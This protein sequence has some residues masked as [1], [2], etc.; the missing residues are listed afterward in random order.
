VER[1]GL[2][3]GDVIRAEDD[4]VVVELELLPASRNV[5]LS[6]ESLARARPDRDGFRAPQFEG[7]SIRIRTEGSRGSGGVRFMG[8]SGDE[9]APE[10]GAILLSRLAANEAPRS[11]AVGTEPVCWLYHVQI[12]EGPAEEQPIDPTLEER[13]RELGYVR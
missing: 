6:P 7:S 5:G 11:L 9:L 8:A 2:E 13:L 4:Q 10:D 3:V 12:E 1:L